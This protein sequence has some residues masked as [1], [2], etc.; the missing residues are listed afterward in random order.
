MICKLSDGR[1]CRLIKHDQ[2]VLFDA[3]PGWSLVERPINP[4]HLM[5]SIWWVPSTTIVWIL[6]F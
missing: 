6:N 5:K 3:R 1:I 4:T 2:P